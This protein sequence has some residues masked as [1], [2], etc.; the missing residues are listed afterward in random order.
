MVMI[1]R[2]SDVT[3][4]KMIDPEKDILKQ[5]TGVNWYLHATRNP[6]RTEILQYGLNENGWLFQRPHYCNP[7]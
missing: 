5:M 3:W 4:A 6:P 7:I 2:N 1:P